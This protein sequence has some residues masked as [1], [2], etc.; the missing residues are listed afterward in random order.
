MLS[1]RSNT[2]VQFIG[3]PQ[4][5]KKA[6]LEYIQDN[7]LIDEPMKLF[8][9]QNAYCNTILPQDDI[10]KIIKDC[11]LDFNYAKQ[12]RHWV[13]CIDPTTDANVQLTN[14]ALIVSY[15]QKSKNILVPYS[16]LIT[17]MDTVA[18]PIIVE[19]FTR[20]FQKEGSADLP[21]PLQTMY[22]GKDNSPKHAK[23]YV[24]NIL[25]VSRTEITIARTAAG[26]VNPATLDEVM[27]RFQKEFEELD[28][29]CFDNVSAQKRKIYN[30]VRD[31]L[32][33]LQLNNSDEKPISDRFELLFEKVFNSNVLRIHQ[34]PRRDKAL[35][36]NILGTQQK[37]LG[38]IRTEALDDLRRNFTRI[39]NKAEVHNED[40]EFLVDEIDRAKKMP[41]FNMHRSNIPSFLRPKNTEAVSEL[42]LIAK[43]YSNR[44]LHQQPPLNLSA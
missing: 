43:K 41:V 33:E 30:L 8:F 22:C 40:L 11:D 24:T 37:L 21:R 6:F 35:G 34:N 1:S 9:R 28:E 18:V 14:I 7:V 36:I 32:R 42:E 2:R 19:K 44:L 3:N 39:E 27:E 23:N 25:R 12:P 17:K 10:D 20:L 15:I 31:T 4:C 26:V 38:M 13:F 5:G 16:L 29:M